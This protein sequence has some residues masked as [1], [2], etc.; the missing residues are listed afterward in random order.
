MTT[1]A[2]MTRGQ[3]GR[4]VNIVHDDPHVVARMRRLGFAPGATVHVQRTA[5]LG[6]PVV[7]QVSGASICLRKAQ[8]AAITVDPIP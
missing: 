2:Q 5:P 4:V 3:R 8:S 7:Y 1:L 6:D